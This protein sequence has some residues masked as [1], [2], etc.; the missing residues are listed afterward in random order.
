M[1]TDPIFIVGNVHSGTTLLRRIIG[2]HPGVYAVAG[3]TQL[4]LNLPLHRQQYPNLK[5]ES[6]LYTYVTY[7]AKVV[8]T[9]YGFVHNWPKDKPAPLAEF[10]LNE[11]RID[12]LMVDARRV[13]GHDE[14]IKIVFD[15]LTRIEGKT[16]WLEK[17]PAHLLCIDQ[18]IKAIPNANFIELVRDPRDILISKHKRAS[19]EWM[20]SRSNIAPNLQ[21]P[22]RFQVGYDPVWDSLTWKS[23]VRIGGYARQKYHDNVLRVRYEDLVTEPEKTVPIICDFINM[24]FSPELL[25]VTWT[26]NTTAPD[27]KNAKGIGPSAIG[28]GT[29]LLPRE[30][31][32]VCQWLT[33]KEM[34]S[35]G[36]QRLPISFVSALKLPIVLGKS[37]IE[38][39]R[40]L[41]LRWQLGGA[42]YIKDVMLKNVGF[43]LR[44]SFGSK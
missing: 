14:I 43:R 41:Y 24:S 26:N 17:T 22:R 20:E 9:R 5:D 30:A 38:L 11:T 10:G 35:L 29:R 7:I 25:N 36:Y 32:V 31:I 42:Y 1:T 6:T 15:H 19:K 2:A 18:I 27:A 34:D 3:E 37:G 39:M 21:K 12:E 23:A 16:R 13:T 4:F 33:R 40:R 44:K 28:K 8:K